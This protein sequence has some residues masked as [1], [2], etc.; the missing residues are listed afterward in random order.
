MLISATTV[1]TE[2]DGRNTVVVEEVA[3]LTGF[4]LPKQ[5]EKLLYEK[6]RIHSMSV[7]DAKFWKYAIYN[8][9]FRTDILRPPSLRE[10][11]AVMTQA[12]LAP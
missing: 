4:K 8:R 9:D 12:P 2:S 3:W 11:G 7:Y 6:Q 5:H 10:V 1:N